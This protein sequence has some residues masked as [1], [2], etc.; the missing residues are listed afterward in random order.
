MTNIHKYVCM[1]LVGCLWR[2]PCPFCLWHMIIFAIELESNFMSNSLVFQRYT[3]LVFF[4]TFRNDLTADTQ[5]THQE[6]Q[7]SLTGMDRKARESQDQQYILLASGLR[8]YFASCVRELLCLG[9]IVP[10]NLGVS[11]N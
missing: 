9:S 5:Y 4:G 10:S 11:L 2:V 8:L 3:A 6:T 1:V 7:L